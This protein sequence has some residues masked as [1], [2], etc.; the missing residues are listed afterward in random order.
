MRIR[1]LLA[2]ASLLGAMLLPGVASAQSVAYAVGGMNMRAGP[3]VEYPVVAIVSPGSA[4]NVYGCISGARWCD[5]SVQGVRGWLG[6]ERLEFV[7]S[8]R[9]VLVPSYYTYFRAPVIGFDFGYWDRYYTGRTFYRDRVRYGDRRSVREERREDRQDVR[10]ER[11]EDRQDVRE[12][13]QEDRQDVRVERRDERQ[14]RE[15]CLAKGG[16][17][18][19]CRQ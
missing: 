3:G 8:G 13:R 18:A 12:E 19:Q 16:T 15:K 6:G 2:A 17:P 4:V 9:R 5:S 11:R 7:Y 14:D 10:E 1:Q